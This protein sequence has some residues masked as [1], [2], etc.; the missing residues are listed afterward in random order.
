[1]SFIAPIIAVLGLLSGAR[2]RRDFHVCKIIVD[3]RC[4]ISQH[5]CNSMLYFRQ[6]FICLYFLKPITSREMRYPILV[7]KPMKHSTPSKIAAV[8]LLLTGMFGSTSAFAA[9]TTLDLRGGHA[10]VAQHLVY[11]D[12][13][14]ASRGNSL[15]SAGAFAPPE[16][17]QDGTASQPMA[18]HG[19][20]NAS[21]LSADISP[22]PEPDAYAMVAVGLGLICFRRRPKVN[23]KLG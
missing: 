1:M 11:D 21:A 7:V 19:G 12:Q 22:V 15:G 2:R 3:A 18:D 17:D 23:P 9:A 20:N 10:Q 14:P 4:A 16:D 5:C 6:V 13:T 8:S